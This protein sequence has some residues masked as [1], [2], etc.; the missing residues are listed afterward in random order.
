[1]RNLLNPVTHARRIK[2]QA[3]LQIDCAGPW[4]VKVKV[5][6]TN[7]TV[8]YKIKVVS[9]VDLCTGWP[10]FGPLIDGKSAT[11]AKILDQQWLCRYVRPLECG[12]DNG[13]EFIGSEFQE[14]L[15]SY[16]IRP[17]PTTVKNPRAQ[18]VVERMQ[19][20]LGEQ[21]RAKI[22]EEDFAQD[23]D[24]IVQ[25]CAYGIRATSPS[26]FPYSP[27]EM[28]FGRDI[29]FRQQVMVNWELVKQ[30]HHDQSI[31]NNE[32]ENKNRK[33]HEYKV[34]D[35]VLL[36]TPPYERKNEAKI[37]PPTEGPYPITHVYPNGTIRIQ[38]GNFSDK[39]SIRR[40]WPY[41][42]RN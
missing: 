5:S 26:R 33:A 12:H 23:L 21:L 15:Q 31:K 1:M 13:P 22:F 4:T 32:K 35:L 2:L 11:V 38:R 41:T 37:S 29:L 39:V 9:I 18:A 40:V 36:V 10:E 17:V 19:L 27:C 7:E 14:M 25:A 3:N 20:L 6:A 30:Y 24:T 42:P 16:G 28:A 8:T 34:G